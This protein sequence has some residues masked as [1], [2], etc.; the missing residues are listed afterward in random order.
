VWLAVILRMAT[1][2]LLAMSVLPFL[3]GEAV[4]LVSAAGIA[5]AWNRLRR[6]HS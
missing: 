4:K 3:P 5:G 2:H 1:A 6:N